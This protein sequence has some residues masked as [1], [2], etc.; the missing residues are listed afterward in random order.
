MTKLFVLGNG[1][2][3]KHG[4]ETS[5]SDFR[6]YLRVKHPKLEKRITEIF[7]EHLCIDYHD[8]LT[9]DEREQE[10]TTQIMWNYFEESLSCFDT[11]FF[12][13]QIDYS[14][15]GG[16]IDEKWSDSFWHDAQYQLEEETSVFSDLKA[17]FVEWVATLSISSD[18]RCRTISVSDLFITFNYTDTLEKLYGVP[19][20]SV[21]HLHGQMGEAVII[22][23]A[24]KYSDDFNHLKFDPDGNDSLFDPNNE[25]FR[26]DELREIISNRT[27]AFYK[28]TK[29]E[30]LPN[31]NEWLDSKGEIDEIIVFGHSYGKADWEY[32][33]YLMEKFPM[34]NWE[35]NYYSIED[36][37]NLRD[38]LSKLSSERKEGC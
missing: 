35:Y 2:D 36:K 19:K 21:F 8:Y 7:D 13:E 34:I 3:L 11:Y 5:Y 6:E 12:S 32:F 1:F 30:I 22:G 4:L 16:S 18:F 9:D 25:D 31:L 15:M 17:S 26:I 27:D 10:D 29:E 37:Q 33:R 38:M 14:L 20:S 23:H 24:T 28:P